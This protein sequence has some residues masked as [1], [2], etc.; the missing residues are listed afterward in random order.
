[1]E[2]W[3]LRLYWPDCATDVSRACSSDS[4][5]SRRFWRLRCCS[6]ILMR[7]RRSLSSSRSICSS[8]RR[9]QHAGW[10]FVI[11]TICSGISSTWPSASSS[12][13]SAFM[14]RHTRTRRS[15]GPVQKRSFSPTCMCPGSI[16][17]DFC[18]S[19]L[20]EPWASWRST[21]RESTR[22]ELLMALRTL[23]RYSVSLLMTMSRCCTSTPCP[24]AMQRATHVYSWSADSRSDSSVASLHAHAVRP[25]LNWGFLT[26]L[27]SMRITR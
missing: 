21:K 5:W 23:K 18:P 6:R 11:S 22:S 15:P 10:G 19:S 2:R 13:G 25:S 24:D 9:M 17:I 3:L 7:S 8:T 20:P 12:P 16:C 14:A 1:M 4:R 27:A 26:T